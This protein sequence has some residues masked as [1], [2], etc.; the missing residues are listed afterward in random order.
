MVW[1]QAS[2]FKRKVWYVRN[3]TYSQNIQGTDI[4]VEGYDSRP[5]LRPERNG[6]FP[7]VHVGLCR[8]PHSGRIAI[9]VNDSF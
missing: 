7:D 4:S 9:L 2:I 1:G 3:K 6:V 5:L 8:V